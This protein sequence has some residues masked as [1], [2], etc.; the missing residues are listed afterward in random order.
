MVLRFRCTASVIA[1][2]GALAG[3]GVAQDG[4]PAPLPAIGEK[5]SVTIM[6]GPG[7]EP[8]EFVVIPVDEEALADLG[9]PAYANAVAVAPAETG[10]N[11]EGQAILLTTDPV[12]KVADTYL[13]TAE[14]FEDATDGIVAHFRSLVEGVGEE[15]R[16]AGQ[17]P[18][19]VAAKVADMLGSLSG[20]FVASREHNVMIAIF[21]TT[22][23]TYSAILLSPARQ[24]EAAA[25]AA[26][27]E[28]DPT[29]GHVPFNENDPFVRMDT[30]KGT[31]YIELF[32][33]EAPVTVANFLKLV[34]MG[35]YDGLSFHRVI[36][37]FMIQGGAKQDGPGWTINLEISAVRHSRGTLSMARTN[38][39]NSASAQFFI[40]HDSA[41]A[42]HLDGQYAAFGRVVHGIEAV[43][44][45]VAAAAGETFPAEQDCVK[46]TSVTRTT[47]P[48]VQRV[49]EAEGEAGDGEAA[50]GDAP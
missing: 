47:W 44:A 21:G 6:A 4:A 19:A 35:Y 41:G 39:P 16:K 31:L 42:K 20:R 17:E 1:L 29:V 34:D 28:E 45:I 50:E 15:L 49:I 40:V 30:E 5:V 18:D 9:V 12:D 37:G 3:M 8:E 14:G 38:D 43:D 11:A 13:A 32:E 23:G 36:D 26:Q 27:P 10:E 22:E 24:E 25:P 48:Q 7:A 2:V 33:T 46:I